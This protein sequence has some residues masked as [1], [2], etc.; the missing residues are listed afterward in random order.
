MAMGGSPSPNSVPPNPEALQQIMMVIDDRAKALLQRLPAEAQ[1]DLA[2][3]LQARIEGGTVLNP[4][5]WM[6]KS[7][8]AAG[9]KTDSIPGGNPTAMGG[10]MAMGLSS[11]PNSVPPNPEALQQIYMLI[12]DNANT[13]LQRLPEET[14]VDLASC[15]LARIESGTVQNPSAWMVKS[16]IGKGA[17]TESIPGGNPTAVGGN[18]MAMGGSSS[19]RSMQ[20][21]PEALQQ[22]MMVIDDK[23]KTLLQQLP[24][25]QQVDLASCLQSKVQDGSI[26]NPSGW[27]VRSAIAAGAGNTPAMGG[28]PMP[29]GGNTMT[30]GSMSGGY[31]VQNVGMATRSTTPLMPDALPQVMSVLDQKAQSLL[32]QLP[33]EKQVDLASFLQQKMGEG[34]IRNPSAWMAKSCLAAGAMT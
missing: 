26:M 9:A 11:S 21:D 16:C 23:A 12:D 29:M 8:I 7:C 19:Q 24:Y 2:S 17:K 30:M 1:V 14:Q 13:L 27:M 5:G 33:Y 10:M 32:Q 20:S 25:E 28:N 22:I 4:S 15:L 31:P 3:C 34:G 18:P 6:V